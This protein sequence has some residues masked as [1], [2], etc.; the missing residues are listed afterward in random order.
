LSRN[1]AQGEWLERHEG[2]KAAKRERDIP[3]LIRALK[4]PDHRDL[5]ARS[6]GKLRA[7]EAVEPLI[8]LL[9]A[10]DSSSQI[11]A[12]Q[13]LGELGATEAAWTLRELAQNSDNSLTRGWSASV[14]ADLGSPDALVVALPLLRDSSRW[15]RSLAVGALGRLGDPRALEPLRETRPTL[16]PFLDWMK[17]QGSYRRAI[18]AVRRRSAGKSTWTWPYA[19]WFRRLR[20]LSWVLGWAAIYLVI[21]LVV[22]FWW[23]LLPVAG[24]HVGLLFIGLLSARNLP[25]G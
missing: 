20:R 11:T 2:V 10:W 1:K 23:A 3:A 9:P 25:L 16:N 8:E 4:D 15:A 12:V 17:L 24:V 5:A 7:A 21:A 14:L 22:G 18:A 19:T 13:V 6:L